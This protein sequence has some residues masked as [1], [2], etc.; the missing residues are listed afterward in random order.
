VQY[1]AAPRHLI[2]RTHAEII[3]ACHKQARRIGT[4]VNTSQLTLCPAKWISSS[5]AREVAR[6]MAGS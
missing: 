3:I 1:F 4:T 2:R 5:A 6:R